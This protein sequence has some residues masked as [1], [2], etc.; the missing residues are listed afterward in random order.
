MLE[1]LLTDVPQLRYAFEKSSADSPHS[2]VYLMQ[3]T[4]VA[5][6]VMYDTITITIPMILT[7]TVKSSIL[8]NMAYIHIDVQPCRIQRQLLSSSI[9]SFTLFQMASNTNFSD[10]DMTKAVKSASEAIWVV[11]FLS[12]LRRSFRCLPSSLS[13]LPSRF[14]VTHLQKLSKRAFAPVARNK[15]TDVFI[16]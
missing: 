14:V 15:K 11:T 4:L 7:I 6:T 5:L 1:S 16:S 9:V 8:G 12:V 10:R 2:L 3:N 13:V